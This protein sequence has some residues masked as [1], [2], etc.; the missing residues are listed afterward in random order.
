MVHLVLNLTVGVRE[1][2]TRGSTRL[3]NTLTGA[4]FL[5]ITG[6]SGA[7]NGRSAADRVAA[8][9][10]RI[11]P[12]FL[13]AFIVLVLWKGWIGGAGLVPAL[14]SLVAIFAFLI[15]RHVAPGSFATRVVAGLC[16][17]MCGLVYG[18]DLLQMQL[19]F[20]VACT[21]MILYQ[22]WRAMMPGALVAIVSQMASGG[23]TAPYLRLGLSL[24]LAQLVLCAYWTAFQRRQTLLFEQQEHQ[25]QEA[26]RQAAQAA[27]ARSEFLANVS[28]EIRTPMN[29]VLGMTRLLLDT[30]LKRDQRELAD[31]LNRSGEALLEVVNGILDFSE[32]DAGGVQLEVRSFDLQQTLEEVI[33]ATWRLARQK[34]LTLLARFDPAIPSIVLGDPLRLRQILLHFATNAL[35]FTDAGHVIVAIKLL[36]AKDGLPWACLEVADTGPGIE[37]NVIPNL[38]R[39]FTHGT[40]EASRKHS[41]TGL[42]LATCERL[43]NLMGGKVGVKSRPEIGSRF[44]AEIPLTSSAAAPVLGLAGKRALLQMADTVMA[45]VI[46]TQLGSWGIAALAAHGDVDWRTIDYLLID[47]DSRTKAE[48][49]REVA[50][51]R[52]NKPGIATIAFLNRGDSR[53][54][55]SASYSHVDHL[56]RKPILP[57]ELLRVLQAE[58]QSPDQAC[59]SGEILLAEDNRINQ[60]VATRLLAKLGYCCDVAPNGLAALEALEKKSYDAILMDCQMPEMDGYRATREIRRRGIRTPVIALTAFAMEGDRDR[61]IEAG[62]DDYVAKPVQL[63]ELERTLLRWVTA[64]AQL[65]K[66]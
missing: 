32:I 46:A 12:F 48:V 52:S 14:V 56:L 6:K 47:I 60:K 33:E 55:A 58:P 7:E 64:Q 10:D 40:A 45:D 59:H 50:T 65:A 43:V 53:F 31:T 42:G 24:T 15:S 63:E 2:A 29:G 4:D 17:H 49:E 39:P 1:A 25:L 54:H 21:A 38:F 51:A 44:W 22:D 9:G 28:H 3:R 16:L 11:M 35:K 57:R 8:R 26:L 34:D 37:G 36:P 30:P 13:A 5:P 19:S 20:F 18:D 66:R 62:M 61:C 41:G 27:Q 23:L